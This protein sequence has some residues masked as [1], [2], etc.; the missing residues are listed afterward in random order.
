MVSVVSLKKHID[1]FGLKLLFVMFCVEDSSSSPF[2]LPVSN[3]SD[4]Y[5]ALLT[6][7]NHAEKKNNFHL[8]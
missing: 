4:F 2:S 5:L 3:V 8:L 1:K 6:L 7:E